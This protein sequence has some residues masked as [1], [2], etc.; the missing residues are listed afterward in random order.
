MI[1]VTWYDTIFRFVGVFIGCTSLER[2]AQLGNLLGRPVPNVLHQRLQLL[3]LLLFLHVS[4]LLQQLRGGTKWQRKLLLT[5]RTWKVR[6]HRRRE[7]HRLPCGHVQPLFEQ[8]Y[9]FGVSGLCRGHR[10]LRRGRE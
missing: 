4:L 5:L 1:R 7:L 10:K 3:R 6:R 2:T 9:R 8:Q